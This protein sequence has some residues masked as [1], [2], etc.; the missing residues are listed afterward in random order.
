MY[1]VIGT[2][3]IGFANGALYAGFIPDPLPA[4][5]L[6]YN[7]GLIASIVSGGIIG[8]GGGTSLAE[9]QTEGVSVPRFLFYILP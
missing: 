7:A 6:Y 1:G 8:F 3:L 2:G 9:F 5:D 4:Q